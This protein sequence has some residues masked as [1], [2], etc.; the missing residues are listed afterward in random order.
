[1]SHIIFLQQVIRI[2]NINLKI[3]KFEVCV[4]LSNIFRSFQ[5]HFN[6]MNGMNRG[7][8]TAVLPHYYVPWKENQERRGQ[9]NTLVME[10]L[11]SILFHKS[12]PTKNS[13]F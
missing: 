9:V 2:E 3:F 10:N 4:I 8:E 5:F 7:I 1:M 12:G 13:A 11:N 6:I